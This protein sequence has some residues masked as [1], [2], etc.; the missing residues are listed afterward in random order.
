[1]PIRRAADSSASR[2]AATYIL[3][4]AAEFGLRLFGLL[5]LSPLELHALFEK[6]NQGSGELPLL[7]LLHGAKRVDWL[8]RSL[9]RPSRVEEFIG[10]DRIEHAH[11]TFVENAQDRFF[12]CFSSRAGAFANLFVGERQLQ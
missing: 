5:I 4:T 3:R 9:K 11:A 8:R 12:C 2:T 7:D 1:M 10:N 6:P